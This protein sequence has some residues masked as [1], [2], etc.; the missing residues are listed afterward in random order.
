M[1]GA[2]AGVPRKEKAL[3]VGAVVEGSELKLKVAYFRLRV[4]GGASI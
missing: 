1:D 4:N 3:G 2:V